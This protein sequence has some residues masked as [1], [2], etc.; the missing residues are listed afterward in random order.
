MTLKEWR[1]KHPEKTKEYYLKKGH[2]WYLAHKEK[3]RV[4]NKLWRE[5]NLERF[6]LL[7]A[8]NFVKRKTER[9][10]QMR[11]W[12]LSEGGKISY[13]NSRIKRRCRELQ[14]KIKGKHTTEE[15]ESLLQKSL[16]CCCICGKFVGIKK[17]TKDHIVPLSSE[18]GADDSIKNIQAVCRPCNSIKR[19]RSMEE[20]KQYLFNVGKTNMLVVQYG[21]T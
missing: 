2:A 1:E 11:T 15:W 8:K 18:L 17:L 14:A 9:K 20:L 13:H 12:A 5:N 19:N 7:I 16:G 10:K 4:K 21:R 6:K 3:E